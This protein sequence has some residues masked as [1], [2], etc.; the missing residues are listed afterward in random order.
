[1]NIKRLKKSLPLSIATI[2]LGYSGVSMA[3]VDKIKLCHRSG[4]SEVTIEVDDDGYY[5]GHI[6]HP[7]DTL[8]ACDASD[9][10]AAPD[11]GNLPPD[12][13]SLPPMDYV[14]PGCASNIKT[15]LCDQVYETVDSSYF[16]DSS[17]FKHFD[18]SDVADS[19]SELYTVCSTWDFSSRKMLICH[20]G[21][22]LN[23]A[24]QG[25]CNG[26]FPNHV[27]DYVGPCL[28]DSGNVEQ[29]QENQSCKNSDANTAFFVSHEQY[30]SDSGVA[31]TVDDCG[32]FPIPPDP[33]SSSGASSGG[34]SSGGSSSGASSGGSSS[35]GSSSGASSGGSSSGGSSSG[36][37]SGG[38][39][40]GGSS[41]GTS[42]GGSSS[43]GSSSGASSGGSSSGGSSSGTSSGGSSSGGSSSGTSS[44]GSSSGGLAPA[45]GH[46]GRF[47]WREIFH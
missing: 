21:Q 15:D 45:T 47:N 11:S 28:S 26:H 13:S 3:V 9:S 37:S 20:N 5:N 40:S 25:A 34:S 29:N 8:G 14:V 18:S 41:S 30:A 6:N 32:G 42:S 39:S 1:M 22:T 19:S 24:N 36:T 12:S 38:S 43:G 17:D 27:D 35:G 46:P 31:Q 10:G 23:I 16:D 4:G 33:G 2:L 44:G 7:A